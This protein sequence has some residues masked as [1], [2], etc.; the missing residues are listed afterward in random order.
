MSQL[1]AD[2]A[3]NTE[4]VATHVDEVTRAELLALARREDRSVSWIL[5]R[6]IDRELERGNDNETGE[7]R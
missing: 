3:P 7:A 2:I 5:R 1:A 4:L 6:A